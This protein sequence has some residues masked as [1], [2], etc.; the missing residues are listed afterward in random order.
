MRRTTAWTTAVAGPALVGLS[1]L[2][3][4]AA[5]AQTVDC[6]VYPDRCEVNDVVI[7]RD[8]ITNDSGDTTSK[9][10]VN[11]RTQPETLPFTGGEVVALTLLGAGAVAGGAALVV[12]GRRRA[13]TSV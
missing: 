3:A 13:G 8:E 1:L 2:T 12:A 9:S 6:V 11:A 5:M 10:T 7:D 4:P